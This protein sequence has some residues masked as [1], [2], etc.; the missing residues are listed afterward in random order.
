[1]YVYCLLLSVIPFTDLGEAVPNI[2]IIVLGLLLP[3]VLKKE[4]I[5]W[6]KNKTIILFGALICIIFIEILVFSRWEDISFF[7]R[8]GLLIG[9]YC[10]SVP[11]LAKGNVKKPMYSF[12][13]GLILLLIVS[14]YNIFKELLLNHDFSLAVGN[15][16]PVLL[17][18]RPYIGFAYTTGVFVSLFLATNSKTKKE[19]F[20]MAGAAL[21]LLGFLFFISARTSLL[22]LGIAGILSIFYKKNIRVKIVVLSVIIMSGLGLGFFSQTFKSR[23]TLGFKQ[24]DLSIEKIIKLEPRYYIWG[25]AKDIIKDESPSLFG[26]GFVLTQEKLNACYANS[27]KFYNKSQ[28]NWFIDEKFN[29]HNQYLNFYLSSGLLGLTVFLT[30]CLFCLLNGINSFYALALNISILSFLLFENV[31]SRQMGVELFVLT[32]VFSNMMTVK[33]NGQ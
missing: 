5:V 7:L 33:N 23:L 24:N 3:F 15:I 26:H 14:S 31:L 32:L 1:M 12:L 27:Q 10:L 20:L 4:H 30:A 6:F 17:G 18:D 9:L 2:I 19:S 25:C 21:V 29:T 13:T 28:Q 16:N 8:L 11:I 22:S